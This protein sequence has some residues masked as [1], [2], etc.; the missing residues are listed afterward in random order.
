[1]SDF[2][3][4]FIVLVA[5]L[6]ISRAFQRFKIPWTV[7]LIIGGM[8]IGPFGFKLIEIDSTLEFL[9]HLGL[10][11]LMFMA[12]LETR[13]SGIKETWR[14][15]SI[16]SVSTGFF[17]L[18]VGVVI[19]LL[20]GYGATTSILLGIVFISSS[21]AI[22]IPMLEAKG[23]S[24]SKI[25][26]TITSSIIIQDVASLIILAVFLQYLI[27][28]N[29]PLPIFIALF[30]LILLLIATMRWGIPKLRWLFSEKKKNH[31]ERDL[32]IVV[33][34]LLGAVIISE[35]LG[36]HSIVGAFL[37]RLILSE[38][39]ESKALKAK[40]HV[41]AYGLFIPVFFVMI[42]ASTNIWIFLEAHSALL[43][44]FAVIIGSI[45][46]KFFSG[47]LSAKIAGFTF[48]QSTLVGGT[49]IPQLSTTL[50][51]VAVGQQYELL[52]LE[53]AT[54]LVMLSII[55]VFVSPIIMNYAAEKAKEN[56][57]VVKEE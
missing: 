56:Y 36:L 23:L 6:V 54:A 14:E 19:A 25:G 42:G 2:L 5:A 4:F 41:M 9:K 47:L 15:A 3:S 18:I 51:V 1:M 7:A 50:A 38:V 34:V 45:S 24:H 11:F 43:L 44:F 13:F 20:L 30:L 52:P 33:A 55:T 10:I 26:K 21:I 31:F 28:G 27:S 32:R 17:P 46:A 16:I 57:F 40:I 12:G 48:M 39:I 29:I 35:L 8:I 37:A 22:A 49:C 53:L